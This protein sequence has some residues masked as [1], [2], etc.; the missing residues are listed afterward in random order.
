M[1]INATIKAWHNSCLQFLV[2][3]MLI[4]SCFPIWCVLQ[5]VNPSP[6]CDEKYYW[7]PLYKRCEACKPGGHSCFANV[8]CC[9]PG[10]QL[11]ESDCKALPCKS[12][13]N[14]DSCKCAKDTDC[15]VGYCCSTDKRCRDC[16]NTHARG[17]GLGPNILIYGTPDLRPEIPIP[18]KPTPRPWGK[19]CESELKPRLSSQV[20]KSCCINSSYCGKDECC[21]F[22][23]NKCR[24]ICRSKQYCEKEKVLQVRETWCELP[25]RPPPPLK[26]RCKHA[27]ECGSQYC[28]VKDAQKPKGKGQCKWCKSRAQASIILEM[29]MQP[30]LLKC[31]GLNATCPEIMDCVNGYCKFP[32][33]P[34]PEPPAVPWKQFEENCCK[35]KLCGDGRCCRVNHVMNRSVAV[36][37]FCFAQTG[38]GRS[39]GSCTRISDCAKGRCCVE[40]V[41]GQGRVCST[42]DSGALSTRDLKKKKAECT[43]NADCKEQGKCCLVSEKGRYACKKCIDDIQLDS[44]DARVVNS[45]QQLGGCTSATDCPDDHCCFA[46]SNSLDAQGICK[47]C[48]TSYPGSQDQRICETDRDCPSMNG[49]SYCCAAQTH[50]TV[51]TKRCTPM[52]NEDSLCIVG[53]VRMARFTCPCQ[54]G[55]ECLPAAV[56]VA[57][58]DGL[59]VCY[60]RQAIIQT[61]ASDNAKSRKKKNK[62]S[63]NNK[64]LMGKKETTK[65]KTS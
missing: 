12:D 47:P 17:N 43:V 39:Y 20:N 44:A 24:G 3:A 9:C 45:G 51:E 50:Q 16:N 32:S 34:A 14:F 64:K 13:E 18:Q 27:D 56:K 6:H 35:D 8:N 2:D 7:Y 40:L 31:N 15:M 19:F 58:Y 28:C 26:Q 46:A 63:G 49:T 25:S 37:D 33:C 48:A 38:T 29:L 10:V 5:K 61:R 42:C 30:K 53:D 36:C 60:Q 21:T 65:K 54:P 62:K 23:P 59:G 11:V 41:P 55:L 22:K 4:V 52:R 57:G 1:S